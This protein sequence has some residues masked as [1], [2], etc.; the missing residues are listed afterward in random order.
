MYPGFEPRCCLMA[1][2]MQPSTTDVSIQNRDDVV[3]RGDD[4]QPVILNPSQPASAERT[5]R[6]KKSR[7]MTTP[8]MVLV[9]MDFMIIL[10]LW[11]VYEAVSN[12]CALL[13]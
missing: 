1:T 9:L 5:K 2:F 4:D 13:K 7:D 10:L 11:I 8:F 6:R 12:W 3:S